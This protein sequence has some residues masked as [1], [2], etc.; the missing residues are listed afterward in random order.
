MQSAV[1]PDLKEILGGGEGA[2]G[3]AEEVKICRAA[4]S[5]NKS[6]KLLRHRSCLVCA[7]APLANLDCPLDS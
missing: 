3:V 4:G 2:Y 1:L 7:S 6:R 5:S